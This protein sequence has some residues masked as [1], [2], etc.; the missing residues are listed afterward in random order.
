MR[1]CLL[2]LLLIGASFS[3]NALTDGEI[4]AV[5][6]LYRNFSQLRTAT[7]PWQPNGAL[8]CTPPL[9]YGLTC[10]DEPQS[11]IIK[12][13]VSPPLL[14]STIL[15]FLSE[16]PSHFGCDLTFNVILWLCSLV[17]STFR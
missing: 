17:S 10:S 3:A 6:A 4:N 12:L 11:H 14:E 9:F 1:L 2:L 15:L 16:S 5:E 13:Y 8:A 7:P